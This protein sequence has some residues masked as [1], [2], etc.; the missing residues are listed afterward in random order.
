MMRNIIRVARNLGTLA[1]AVALT[2]SLN[3]QAAAHCD[4]LDGPVVQ[5]ARKALSAGDVTP[6]LKW[7]QAKD[8]KAVKD[9]FSKALAA[10]GKKQQE[11]TEKKFF[12]SLVRI[13]RAG[14]GAPFS[15][16]K[17]AGA[18]EPVI[19]AADNALVS[20]SAD[21]LIKTLTETVA[22]GIRQR[23]E[24][25]AAALK[26]KD[27]SVQLGREYVAAYVEYTHYV[28]RLLMT[29]E[30]QSAHHGEHSSKKHAA[31]EHEHGHGH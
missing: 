9:A 19:V 5:D 24:K 30:N 26:H 29:A 1:A 11:P 31:P 4:T 27:E 28:E 7:V 3:S 14:E 15:G 21:D 23:Y 10:Q 25:V 13:H 2:V 20:G 17:P 6:V 16:L 22:K 8:E 18:V 12:E